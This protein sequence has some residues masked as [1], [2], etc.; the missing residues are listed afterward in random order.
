[1]DKKMSLYKFAAIWSN[2]QNQM[3]CQNKWVKLVANRLP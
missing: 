3:E 1:M 2:V